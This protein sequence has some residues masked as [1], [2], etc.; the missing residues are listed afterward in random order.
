MEPIPEEIIQ[1]A[2]VFWESPVG[3]K[4][5]D[6]A[7]S[8]IAEYCVQHG[9]H[10]WAVVDKARAARAIGEVVKDAS[11]GLRA[12][13]AGNAAMMAGCAGEI[14]TVPAGVV[15]ET[16]LGGAVPAVFTISTGAILV[17]AVIFIAIVAIVAWGA[18]D[19]AKK[20]RD[21]KTQ[22]QQRRMAK[23]LSST[24]RDFP[25]TGPAPRYPLPGVSHGA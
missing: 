5:R 8:R 16:A 22:D 18:Y 2:K 7:M 6:L 12:V 10:F 14:G 11:L 9:A 21:G 3:S 20:E 25:P 13:E 4:A 19:W 1:A 15:A 24:L 17:T 23:G